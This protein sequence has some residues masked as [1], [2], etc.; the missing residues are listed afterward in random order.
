MSFLA[1]VG[2][3]VRK[4]MFAPVDHA[5][6]A[7]M[8]DHEAY[9][10]ADDYGP[11]CQYHLERSFRADR[12]L[13]EWVNDAITGP[14]RA[15]ILERLGSPPPLTTAKTSIRHRLYDRHITPTRTIGYN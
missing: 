5:W 4:W 1:N 8:P 7:P 11:C 10:R 12:D 14:Q 15:Y 9:I 13:S 3:A 2:Q 6:S